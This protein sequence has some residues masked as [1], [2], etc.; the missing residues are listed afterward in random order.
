MGEFELSLSTLIVVVLGGLGVY[1]LLPRGTNASDR[2]ARIAGSVLATIAL[3]LLAGNFGDAMPNKTN[4]LTFYLLAAVSIISAVLMIASHNP[5]ISALWFALVLLSNSGLYLLQGAE[6]LSAAT[7]IIYAGAIIVTFLFVIMLAQPNGAAPYDLHSREPLLS[8]TAG[9]ILA[10]TLLGTLHYACDFEGTPLNA[11]QAGASS[12][13]LPSQAL[14][15]KSLT[16]HPESIIQPGKGHVDSL[17]R[18][19]FLDHYVAVE[20]VGMLLLVAV[21]GAVLIV[22]RDPAKLT[23]A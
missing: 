5:V 16:A 8:C 9:V 15:A 14:V 20:V 21:V 1:L 22:N 11:R 6:F 2:V 23:A 19:L 12:A 7:I 18:T 13:A 3:V 4:E 10:W 17:G